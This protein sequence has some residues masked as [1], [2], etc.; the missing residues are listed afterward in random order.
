MIDGVER[1]VAFLRR[2]GSANARR[3][4]GKKCGELESR[5]KKL[6]QEVAALRA[7]MEILRQHKASRSDVVPLR[8][9]N[10]A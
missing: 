3:R 2:A 4:G 10:V 1:R 9:R 5:I 8:D 6:E 7:E